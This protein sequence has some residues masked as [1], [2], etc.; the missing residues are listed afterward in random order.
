MTL[1][2]VVIL[3]VAGGALLVGLAMQSR[4]HPLRGYARNLL[5]TYVS[6]V[7]LLVA[8]EFYLRYVYADSKMEF[9]LTRDNWSN[10]YIQRNSLGFRDREWTMAE[11]ESRTTIFAVGDSFT[12]GWGI[13][14]PTHR[15]TDVLAGLLGEDYAIVNLGHSGDSLI[16]ELANLENYPYQQPDV[17][18]WQYFINDIDV[19]AKSNGMPWD[20]EI[21]PIPAIAQESFLASFFYWRV[22]EAKLF[23]NVHD[24]RSEWEFNYAAYDTPYIWDIHTQEI[25]R[26]MTYAEGV[27]AR[28]IVVIYPNMLDPVGSVKYVDRVAQY[29]QEKGQAEVLK[30]YDEAAAWQLGDRIVSTR[31]SHASVAFNKRVAEMIYAKFFAPE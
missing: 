3:I 29:F 16:H 31:D 20:Y 23:V 13:N 11:L 30:L 14:N 15:Y 19:A 5:I 1:T 8:G 24:G 6:V 2:L 17:I 27:G 28:L 9:A 18:L 10:R 21:P 22:N 12:E 7:L 4:W 26:M 25:D